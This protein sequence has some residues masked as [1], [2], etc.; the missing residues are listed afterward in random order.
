LC[1]G[2]VYDGHAWQWV[3][4]PVVGSR[5]FRQRLRDQ[6]WE[7][8]SPTQVLSKQAAALH[9]PQT[10]QVTAWKVKESKLDPDLVTVAVDPSA[11]TRGCDHGQAA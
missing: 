10:K 1:G 9:F 2:S 7:R 3:N 11:E 6:A 4:Y 8:Q 5:Y